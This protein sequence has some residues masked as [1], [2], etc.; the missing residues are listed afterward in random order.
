MSRILVIDDDPG[1]LDGVRRILE[2]IGH[3]VET[4]ENG[5]VAMRRFEA[6]P[7]DLVITDINMPE[8]DGIEVILALRGDDRGV[9][10]I[11]M[12]AGGQLPRELLLENADMLGAVAA[13]PK[14]FQVADLVEAVESALG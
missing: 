4:A 10:I 14:P 12:S 9:P 3:D 5:R 1:V 6:N 13:V 2:R 7:H 8:M 11:A